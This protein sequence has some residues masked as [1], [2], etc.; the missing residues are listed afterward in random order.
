[1]KDEKK[2]KEQLLNELVELRQRIA[3][4][5]KSEAEIKMAEE[6]LRESAAKYKALFDHSLYCVFVHDFEGRFMDAN[7]AALNLLG[8][9]RED[10]PSVDFSTLLEKDQLSVTFKNMEEL[11]QTGSQK[12][13]IE[14]K[15]RKKDGGY[16]W[17]EAEGSL[18]YKEGKPYA[19]QGIARDITERKLAEKAPIDS[20]ER[21]RRMVSAIP[22]YTYSVEVKDGQ[23]IFTRHSIGC[24]PVTGY[25]PEDYKFE[26]YLWYTMIHPEDQILVGNSL[27]EI[28]AG[29][30]VTPRPHSLIRR[31]GSIVWVR[32]T[33][34]PYKDE[35]GRLIRYDGLIEDI[36]ERKQA[37]E[38][39]QESESKFR[40]LAQTNA[41]AI[42]IIQGNNF[43]YVNP[44]LEP[45]TGYS[46]EELLTINFWDF[47]HPEF[48]E[49]VKERGLR[50]QLGEKVPLRYEFKIITKGGETRWL[51]TTAGL[52]EYKGKPA[53]IAV[54]FETTD[55]KHAEEALRESE[56]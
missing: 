38:A 54:A 42:F 22:A 32:N 50:R 29:R 5:G 3:E 6:A 41:A 4:M 55:R 20:E 45:I 14:Y 11:L 56:E 40:P 26:P 18:I 23:A 49:L 39:M 1:M 19:I 53:T 24:L 10:I 25:K 28:M 12:E 7:E 48:Q 2:T 13:P 27:N 17:I 9:K 33:M 36:T 21:Y 37:E 30:E 8:Y 46:E 31:D 44:A 34:V 52:I 47:V 51:D 16:V 15:L 43:Q 35:E